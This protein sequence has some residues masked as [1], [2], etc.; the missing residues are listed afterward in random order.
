MGR[1]GSS[2]SR[3]EASARHSTVSIIF[4]AFM[5]SLISVTLARPRHLLKLF[6]GGVQTG[7]HGSDRNLENFG[8]FT[9]FQV[10]VIRQDQR[11]TKSIG[12][13]SNAF[14]NPLLS[15]GFL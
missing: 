12:E 2:G 11:L 10:L 9:V 3:S 1:A 15:L 14:P 7:L 4:S 13:A 8:D 6:Q 5:A